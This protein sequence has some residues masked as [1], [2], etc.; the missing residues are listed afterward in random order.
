[1][2]CLRQYERCFNGAAPARARNMARGNHVRRCRTGFNGA[3]PARAR[4]S[5][6]VA[7][8]P[9]FENKLQWGRA[10]AGAEIEKRSAPP[11]KRLGLQW[12]RARAGAEMDRAELRINPS[13]GLQWGRARAGA[14]MSR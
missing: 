5:F 11:Q 3:A 10:R 7:F 6:L 4:R 14:E 9:E 2:F 12:G 1:M 13:L 8:K